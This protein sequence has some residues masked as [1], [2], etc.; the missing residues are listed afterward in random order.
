MLKISLNLAS[1][2]VAKEKRW[3]E[4]MKAFRRPLTIKLQTQEVCLDMGNLKR[5][6]R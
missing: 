4:G 1:Q 3:G 2:I 5:R 6:K